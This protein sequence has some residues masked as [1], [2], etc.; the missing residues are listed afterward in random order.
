MTGKTAHGGTDHRR[1]EEAQMHHRC[2]VIVAAEISGLGQDEAT[3]SVRR[4]KP[5][6]E[7]AGA[8][9]RQV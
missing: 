4:R 5:L 3:Q 7:I 9:T 6:V 2:Y 1:A 8:R